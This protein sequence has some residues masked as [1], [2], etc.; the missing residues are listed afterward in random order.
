VSK[1]IAKRHEGLRLKAY[2]DPASGGDPWTIGYGHT[3]GVKPGATCTQEMAD[4]WFEEDW[5]EARQ[6]VESAVT[7][8]LS[9]KQ[10]DALTSF[11]FNVGA[12]AFRKSTLLKL[13][14]AG[15]YSGAA[16]QLTRWTKAAGKTMPGLVRR[17]GE[18]RAWF[19]SGTGNS[20]EVF[21]EEKPVAPFLIAAI[22]AL[23][24]ALPEFAKIFSKPD[25]K[26]RNVEAVVKA[27][28]LI[29][30]ATGS[31]NVQEAVE[32][33]QAEPEMA[34]AANDSLRLNRAEIMDLIERGWD[35]DD[36]SVADA[37]AF[38]MA[39]QPV[40]GRFQFIHLMSVLMIVFCGIGA[41]I[42]LS[43]PEFSAEIKGSVITLMLIGGWTG[44]LTFW[45]GSSRSS[46]VKDIINQKH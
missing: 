9:D 31:V 38:S 2:P 42:V 12:G 14:N 23:V 15:D 41:V 34:Q 32:K 7:V 17:R 13:L 29:M 5:A 8:P 24:N 6:G 21:E 26:E 20:V 4:Q 19:L 44:V 43:L 10:R 35:R 40:L 18:E 22:P 46:Q 33:V 27:S 3:K 37:R 25:V 39:D 11:V 1:E 30:Q 36:K 28:E 45:F 16:N